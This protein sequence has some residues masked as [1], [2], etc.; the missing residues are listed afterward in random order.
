MPCRP[1]LNQWK[2]NLDYP[3]DLKFILESILFSAQKP[4]NPKELRDLL[5]TAAEGNAE[6]KPWAKTKE[7][8][9]VKALEE[10]QMDH[11]AAARSYRLTCVA[12]SWQFVTQPEFS[13]W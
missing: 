12:G 6:A 3:M 9:L 1:R 10:L 5:A 2:R 8:D 4:L 7:A 13:P 11:E